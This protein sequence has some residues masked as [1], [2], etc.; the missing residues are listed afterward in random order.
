[1]T[2]PGSS[3]KIPSVDPLYF[4]EIQQNSDNSSAFSCLPGELL[5]D[6]LVAYASWG[7]LARLA[8]VQSSWKNLVMDA[9]SSEES[10][11]E[12]AQAL[13]EGTHDL[14]RNHALALKLLHQL[15]GV[16]ILL[17]EDGQ[18][19]QIVSEKPFVPAMKRLAQCYLQ[20]SEGVQTGMLWLR[21]AYE[22]GSDLDAAFDLA[23]IH[24]HG[25]YGTAT[26]PVL[27]TNWFY[28][29]AQG[30]HVEGMAEYA[31]CCELGCGRD[32]DDEEAFDWYMKA[33]RK[34]HVTANFSVGEAF[35]EA[36]G[37]P[38][39]DQEAC[40]WYYRAALKGDEDSLRALRR[41]NDIARIVV[42]GVT[43]LLG[44]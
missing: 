1:M 17:G 42:P 29:A 20:E 22:L 11:W 26:N 35:E 9:A 43:A 3:F 36:R 33:A 15:A 16:I 7:G 34:G 8:C 37:V 38:Q 18:K 32:A 12:L 19:F 25:K 31:M 27:A 28:K 24:E 6:C 14:Q 21:A 13:M 4:S 44:N 23:S 10:K 2:M 39:S 41:L 30:G 5:A 40:L